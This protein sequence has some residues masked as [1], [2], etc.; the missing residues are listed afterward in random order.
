MGRPQKQTAE[1]R[2]QHV[3]TRMTKAELAAYQSRVREANLDSGDF[4]RQALLSG[5]VVVRRKGRTDPAVILQLQRIGVNLNQIA[6]TCNTHGGVPD[7]LDQLCRKVEEIVMR[8]VE[9]EG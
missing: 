5:Q 3:G 8:A 4:N 1:V 9:Q 6:R 2:D 7:N